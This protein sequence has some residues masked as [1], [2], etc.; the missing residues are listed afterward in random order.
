MINEV[1]VHPSILLGNQKTVSSNITS[2]IS[3]K[4]V[5]ILEMTVCIGGMLK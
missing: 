4:R 3:I 1:N 5:E 2:K